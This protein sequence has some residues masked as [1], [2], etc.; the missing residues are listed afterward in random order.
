ML[1]P[2]QKSITV[3]KSL[4]TAGL[5]N[6]SMNKPWDGA[7]DGFDSMTAAPSRVMHSSGES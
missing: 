5:E 1:S 3:H 2:D 6:K 4:K 7:G